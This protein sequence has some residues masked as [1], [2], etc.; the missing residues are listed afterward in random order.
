MTGPLRRMVI[1]P[2]RMAF[3]ALATMFAGCTVGPDFKVPDA[4][5]VSDYLPKGAPRIAGQSVAPGA[6]IP[7]RWWELFQS[8]HLNRLIEQGLLQNAELQAAEA[9]VRAAQA[10]A[11]AQRG[12]L[13]PQIAGN[14]T[15]TRQETPTST[16]ST[17]A[18]SGAAIYTVHTAQ[19]TVSFVPDV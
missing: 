14:L 5:P 17:N 6:D 8:A 18:A 1:P 10:S 19:A 2:R 16:L 7:S 15:S 11:L 12:A 9:S 4:P 3:L 13:F